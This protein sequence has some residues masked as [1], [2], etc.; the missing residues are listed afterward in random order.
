VCYDYNPQ[1]T[2]GGAVQWTCSSPVEATGVSWHRDRGEDNRVDVPFDQAIIFT[3]QARPGPYFQYNYIENINTASTSNTWLTRGFS[4]AGVNTAT[5]PIDNRCGCKVCDVPCNLAVSGPRVGALTEDE[6]A[7]DPALAFNPGL[8]ACG[9]SSGACMSVNGNT[10]CVGT[11]SY[12]RIPEDNPDTCTSLCS[13]FWSGISVDLP[14]S[15]LW[16][17][18]QVPLP[19]W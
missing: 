14:L 5:D 15:D 18:V 9:G 11:Q 13:N 3:A 8:E 12:E 7:F 6:E 10:C 16:S 2:P 17:E 1:P 4:W 19:A